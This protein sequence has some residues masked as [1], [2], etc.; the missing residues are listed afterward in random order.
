V[1]AFV[2]NLPESPFWRW[3]SYPEIATLRAVRWKELPSESRQPL[4]DRL[5]KGPSLEA[6]SDSADIAV[7]HSF[8]RDHELARIV[9]SGGPISEEARRL[10]EARRQK[11]KA[12]PDHVP[13]VEPGVGAVPV[14]WVPSG[15]ARKFDATSTDEL[16]TALVQS[17]GRYHFGEG[18]D[19]E[20]FGRTP[21]G[22]A[23]IVEALESSDPDSDAADRGWQLLLTYPAQK[24]DDAAVVRGLSERIVDLALRQPEARITSLA[25]RLSYWLD[26]ADE[27]VPGFQGS[28]RLWLVLL[29][30]T[31]ELA[32]EEEAGRH[33]EDRKPPDLTM[34]ALN[35]PLGHL[36]SMFLRR[37]PPMS[38]HG[39]RSALPSG[40]TEPL[41][42]LTGR[43]A[44]TYCE[45]IG[46]TH[47]LLFL[48][49]Q[50]VA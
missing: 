1:A 35:E 4:E 50:R 17:S 45:S 5:L 46:S 23:R 21:A 2:A 13:T 42:R 38:K 37:C 8:H 28:E 19:A 49:G 25:D 32:N 3:T 15:D 14:R 34:A 22:K 39:E 40:F 33:G 43:G 18:D 26:Q 11:D 10:V 12:F 16:L 29:P 7:A 41:K 27:V 24:A 36:I 31:A 48:G 9:D 44:R 6:F 20:A 47:E 30:L